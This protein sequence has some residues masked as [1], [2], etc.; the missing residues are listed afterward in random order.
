MPRMTGV[1]LARHLGELGHTAPIILASGFAKAGADM[2]L[3]LVPLAKPFDQE[4]LR[5]AVIQALQTGLLPMV[6]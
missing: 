1:E 2:G 3:A 4:Q 5:A 6:V